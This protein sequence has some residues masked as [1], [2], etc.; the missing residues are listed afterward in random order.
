MQHTD[1][2][3]DTI[4]RGTRFA[5]ISAHFPQI[6]HVIAARSGLEIN[7]YMQ[8][9]QLDDDELKQLDSFF[10]ENPTIKAYVSARAIHP[11]YTELLIMINEK[12]S[13][14]IFSL[15]NLTL[16]MDSIAHDNDEFLRLVILMEESKLLDQ[17]VAVDSVKSVLTYNPSVVK[18]LLALNKDY[19]SD[20]IRVLTNTNEYRDVN[21]CLSE[22]SQFCITN[23][24]V[25]TVSIPSY[26]KMTISMAEPEIQDEPEVIIENINAEIIKRLEAYI[27]R[28]STPKRIASDGTSSIDFGYNFKYFIDWQSKG[29]EANYNQALQW[30]AKLKDTQTVPDE[31]TRL[32]FA[33]DP[34]ASKR[35]RTPAR[36]CDFFMGITSPELSKIQQD[37]M[38]HIK[39]TAP[40]IKIKL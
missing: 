26:K 11:T 40:L 19:L 29:R 22:Y 15:K 5:Y 39:V 12:L 21:K 2:V 6:A 8:W 31:G 10:S 23:R 7:H 24:M 37:V 18:Y 20:L 14:E 34:V 35:A 16:L 25:P 4:N 27:A 1:P 36:W 9:Y 32:A 3:A 38:N 33:F 13:L 17:L 30:L 28:V